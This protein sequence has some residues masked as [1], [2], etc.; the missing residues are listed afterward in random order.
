[1]A[2]KNIIFAIRRNSK[3]GPEPVTRVQGAAA[4]KAS[5]FASFFRRSY[6]NFQQKFEK[7]R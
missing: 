2:N 4:E 6:V 3:A 7:A 5:A 1:M